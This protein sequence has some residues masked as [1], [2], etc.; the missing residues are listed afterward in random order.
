MSLDSGAK[1]EKPAGHIA[2]QMSRQ[3]ELLKNLDGA[4][5]TLQ[6]NLVEILAPHGPPAPEDEVGADLVGL[7]TSLREHNRS[8]NDMI[9]RLQDMSSRLEL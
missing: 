1:I 6:S 7:A 3:A 8:L 4:V 2:I 5:S 9:V